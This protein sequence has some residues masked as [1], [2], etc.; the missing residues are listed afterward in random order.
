MLNTGSELLLGQV[1]NTHVQSLGR[2]LLEMGLSLQRQVTVP[3]GPPIRE[4]LAEALGRAD[5]VLVT[6]GLGPTSDDITR[7]AVAE[8]LG[9]PLRRDAVVVEAIR[10]RFGR[11][12]MAMPDSNLVQADVPEGA[13]VLPNPNG[14]A[15]GLYLEDRGRHIFLLPGPPRELQPMF[16]EQ[17]APRLRAWG[18][19]AVVCR[20]L[21]TTGM[22][23]SWIQEQIEPDLHA[24]A[25]GVE[26]GYCARPG[27]VDIRLVHAS[28]AARVEAAAAWV[29]DRLGAIVFGTGQ[30]PLEAVVIRRAAELGAALAV[31]ESCTGGRVADRLTGVPGASAVFLGGVVAY[32][33]AEKTR[34]LGVSPALLGEHGAVSEETARA[35]ASGVRERTGAVWAVAT[36]GIAGPSGGTPEKPVGLCWVA[37]AGP[38]GVW[39]GRKLF[40][41]DRE[42]FKHLASQHALEQLRRGLL[43]LG[44]AA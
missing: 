22:G 3:D 27:E 18:K 16:E 39:A 25:T 10:A 32:S 24:A 37:V 20:I 12:G 14:T 19:G 5:V 15:P 17:V 42:T 1:L 13:E 11:R 26:I 38:G 41:A 34:Q 21:R 23:E 6:G 30:E 4:A 40:G 44:P 9:R 36:T 35:M 7:N 29:R 8:L 43:G 28:D 2:R 31:A 33:N